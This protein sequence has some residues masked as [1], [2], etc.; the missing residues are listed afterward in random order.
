[1]SLYWSHR[2]RAEGQN[3]LPCP[4]GHAAFDAALAGFLGCKGTLPAHVEPIIY[5]HPQVLLRAALNPFSTQPVFVLG[6]ATNQ[7]QDL[8][9]GT[10]EPKEV[11]TV[12]PLK[13]VQVPL[14]GIHSP[15][16]VM[17]AQY[18]IIEYPA[19]EGT[20]KDH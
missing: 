6:I 11:H 12:P 1:M 16:F 15:F 17:L 9:L 2:C 18:R 20:P 13:P 7:V 19:L 3:P 4:A 14:D 8:A 10:V 5:Q